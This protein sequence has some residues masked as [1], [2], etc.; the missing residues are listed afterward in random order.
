MPS[1]LP[2]APARPGAGRSRRHAS[3]R[4]RK[5]R[6]SHSLRNGLDHRADLRGGDLARWG[7]LPRPWARRQGSPYSDGTAPRGRSLIG[8][9]SLGSRNADSPGSGH[10][11]GRGG[12]R[13]GD[14]RAT[15]DRA[16]LG[17]L[18]HLDGR[19]RTRTCQLLFKGTELRSCPTSCS[20]VSP[21]LPSRKDL[22]RHG[23]RIRQG[24]A[25]RACNLT[26]SSRGAIAVIRVWG[27][28]AIQ[29]VDAV[30]APTATGGSV[31]PNRQNSARPGR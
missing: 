18:G 19:R 4:R 28:D 21:I 14:S 16:R 29:V 27:P 8:A 9:S 25:A 20:S 2:I 3:G 11:L 13:P 31:G 1:Q 12:C 22:H 10:L 15:S 26:P 7:D 6:T 17:P 24:L 5:T 23:T 30:S